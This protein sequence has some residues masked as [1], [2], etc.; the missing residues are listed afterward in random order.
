MKPDTDE[1][2]T[3][4][5]PADPFEALIANLTISLRVFVHTG[6]HEYVKMM[7]GQSI[8]FGQL[9]GIDVVMPDLEVDRI[10]DILFHGKDPLHELEVRAETNRLNVSTLLLCLTDVTYSPLALLAW[11]KS[12]RIRQQSFI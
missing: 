6:D 5:E 2:A 7:R 10:L 3:P 1:S 4:N 9:S 8:C 11:E 12:D